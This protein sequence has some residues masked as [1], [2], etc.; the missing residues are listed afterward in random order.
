MDLPDFRTPLSQAQDWV[1]TLIDGVRPEQLADPTPCD[2]FDVRTLIGH[3]YAGAG[4]VRRM[5]DGGNALEEPFVVTDL[6]DEDLAGGYRARCHA[7]QQAWRDDAKLTVMVQAPWGE[8]PGAL[9]LAGYLT[10]ALTHGWDLAVATGQK[11]EAD[12]V[13]ACIALDAARRALPEHPRG[14]AVPFAPVVPSAAE[15]GPTEMLANW[16]GR[17][18]VVVGTQSASAR[19]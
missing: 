5:G 8:V 18:G 17:R 12:S 11:A 9:A 4:R 3:L 19:R 1:A 6:A 2:D 16:M 15:A 13:L 10:E 7:A 14:G